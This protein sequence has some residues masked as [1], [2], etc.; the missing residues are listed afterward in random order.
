GFGARR[1]LVAERRH[2]DVHLV[3][4]DDADERAYEAVLS[5]DRLDDDDRATGHGVVAHLKVDLRA[6]ALHGLKPG[7]PSEA[8]VLELGPV[9]HGADA[10]AVGRYEQDGRVVE[11]RVK[12]RVFEQLRFGARVLV[13]QIDLRQK[14]EASELPLEDLEV[15]AQGEGAVLGQQLVL[16]NELL[17]RLLR[18]LVKENPARQ[19]NR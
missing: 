12:M 7:K 18:A 13:G 6:A 14:R 15:V 17:S 5:N 2:D 16:A 11:D 8:A 10:V 3:E 9:G 19:P 1:E 4:G